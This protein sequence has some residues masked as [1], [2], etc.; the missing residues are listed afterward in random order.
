MATYVVMWFHLTAV[1]AW[2]GGMILATF[3]LRP[4]MS[5]A[6]TSSAE[7]QVFRRIENGLKSVRWAAILTLIFT[8]FY[9]LLYEG[10]SDRL[11]SEW[12]AILLVKILIAAIAI[13]LTGVSDFI[14][15]PT[16]GK[17]GSAHAK[18]YSRWISDTVFVLILAILFLGVYLSRT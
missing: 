4:V 17:A 2:L 11:E 1:A 7:Q 15:A 9:N 6:G 5:R 14:I 3:V 12:G 16:V 8:G 18:T 13:A 10:G